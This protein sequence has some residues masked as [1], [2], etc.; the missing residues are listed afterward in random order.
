MSDHHDEPL[1]R[2]AK[3]KTPT[4][5]QQTEYDSFEAQVAA[6]QRAVDEARNVA[7][8]IE[9]GAKQ[10]RKRKTASI[11]I[12]AEDSG[13]YAPAKPKYAPKPLDTTPKT[14]PAPKPSARS[15]VNPD[16]PPTVEPRIEPKIKPE[17]V[18]QVDA[19]APLVR[20]RKTAAPSEKPAT[21]RIAASTDEKPKRTKSPAVSSA[22]TGEKSAAKSGTR[23]KTAEPLPPPKPRT[24]WAVLGSMVWGLVRAFVWTIRH[25][26]ARTVLGMVAV[27]I[28]II[29]FAPNL[30]RGSTPGIIPAKHISPIFTA[31]VQHWGASISKWGAE[32][33]VDPNLL[34]TL[35][36]I[37]SCGWAGA[38]SSAGA[39][40]LFQVM[41]MHFTEQEKASGMTEPE[42]NAKRGAGVISDC[43]MRSDGDV[44]L[45]MACYNGGP[46]LIRLPFTQWP[47]ET[48]RYFT[49]GTGI[50]ND[51]NSS[52]V[53]SP[54]VKQ[55]LDAGGVYLCRTAADSLN[56]QHTVYNVNDGTMLQ[57]N[58]PNLQSISPVISNVPA[59]PLPTF[60]P[61]SVR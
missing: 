27:L 21:Q 56:I 14:R 51:A 12:P 48:Q 29:V 55:W 36:Q 57:S 31:E 10:A 46:R 13:E 37:E 15:D 28:M 6:N 61:L 45:A 4:P 52:K 38:E 49:Y 24:V 1:I 58:S 34:A 40:G 39:Q 25:A 2:K 54:A 59:G 47:A 20:K 8:E 16:T 42:L 3:R 50:Y 33:G 41:P 26:T 23:K 32:Y 7:Q 18:P 60:D 19:N 30:F 53:T 35:I 43:L 5:P 44:G 9:E 22:I 17:Y 11:T